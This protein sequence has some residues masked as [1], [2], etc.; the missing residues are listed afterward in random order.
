M[1][2]AEG[3]PFHP[4]AYRPGKLPARISRPFFFRLSNGAA[5]GRGGPLHRGGGGG[6]RDWVATLGPAGIPQGAL[7]GPARL[8]S[9]G[10]SSTLRN[11]LGPREGG[12]H[13]VDPPDPYPATFQ[14]AQWAGIERCT[15]YPLPGALGSSSGA[16]CLCPCGP[17][18][19][20][21]LKRLRYAP[22]GHLSSDSSKVFPPVGARLGHR[23]KI[24]PGS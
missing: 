18:T 24:M 7:H 17:G 22:L 12:A 23:P 14:Y 10:G 2:C 19:L 13:S 1:S 21:K 8:E 15:R 4:P 5:P 3:W 6:S 11:L 20:S 9:G 16:D